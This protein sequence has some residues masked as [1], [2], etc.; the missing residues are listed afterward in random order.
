M[1]SLAQEVRSHSSRPTPYCR[2]ENDVGGGRAPPDADVEGPG[3]RP[4]IRTLRSSPCA[5]GTARWVGLGV[6]AN[7]W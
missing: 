1:R 2:V 4:A 7:T 5:D 3:A 6:I